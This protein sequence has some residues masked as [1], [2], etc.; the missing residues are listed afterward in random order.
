MRVAICLYGLFNNRFSKT[1]GAEGFSKLLELEGN[2]PDVAFEWFA[3]STDTENRDEISLL[4]STKNATWVIEE[5]QDFEALCREK[6]ID[7]SKFDVPSGFRSFSN[8]LSFFFSR[9]QSI[10]LMLASKRKFDWVIVSRFDVAQL[11]RFN[12]RQRAHVG[13]IGFNRHLCAGM[14][15]SAIWDQH[16]HGYAD[17]WFILSPEDAR[18]LGGMYEEA[19]TYLRD[20]SQYLRFIGDGIL[21]SNT[22]DSFSNE[23]RRRRGLGTDLRRPQAIPVRRD[24]ST[25]LDVHLM[26]KFFF[27]ESGLYQ[28]SEFSTSFPGLSLFMY[29]HSDYSD[30][31]KPF[32]GRINRHL[33]IFSHR[34]I[35]TDQSAKEVAVYEVLRYNPDAAYVDR[36][37]QTLCRVREPFVMFM[38]EDMILFDDPNMRHLLDVM[39]L[40]QQNKLDYFRFS[41]GGQYFALPEVTRSGLSRFVNHLSPWVFSIQPSIWRVSSL[42]RLLEG[43]RGQGIWQFERE[44]QKS[45]RK[46]RLRGGFSNRSGKKK[47]LHHFDNPDFPYIATAIV[48]GKWNLAEYRSEL[49]ELF[50]EYGI[51][52]SVRNGKEG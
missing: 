1:A 21:D 34:Y 26:H 32:D 2:F 5:Q 31:W 50:D 29:S 16:N 48:K 41:K 49:E 17:Q 36:L 9:K 3:Y 51:D 25:G 35:A 6:A 24:T 33:N 22:S 7:L 43:H 14:N 39:G 47:G 19:L 42:L 30:L 38:H 13:E 11:D 52:P 15:Y 46:L 44:A 4:L 23:R 8:A 40:M 28:T 18:I 20:E 27:I 37:I 45:F 12:G 10:E